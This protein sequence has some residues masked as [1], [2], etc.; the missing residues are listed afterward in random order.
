MRQILRIFLLLSLAILTQ[1]CSDDATTPEQEIERFI[2]T[3][4]EAGENRSVDGLTELVHTGF[5]DQQGR[6]RG[7]FE[8]LLRGY[9]IRHKNIH[10]FTRID[11][12]EILGDNQASVHLHV[13][14]AGSV[15]AD[16]DALAALRARIYR[17][18]LQ[19]VKQP[20][21][22]LRQANWAPAR[23]GDLE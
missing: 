1:A 18:E 2:E 17:F 20:D 19:L 9:F 14:M 4:V 11:N 5:V 3:A 22:R 8:L 12:I 15:I 13:A 23:I 10:L 21:W 16:I 7:Q 6:N